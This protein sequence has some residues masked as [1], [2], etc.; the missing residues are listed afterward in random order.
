MT[1]KVFMSPQPDQVRLDTGIGQVVNQLMKHLPAFD[2]QLVSDAATADLVACHVMRGS[3]PRCDVLHS[4]GLYFADIPHEKY[5]PWHY[6]VNR[7][8][9]ASAREATLITVPAPWVANIFKRDM[10][11]SPVVIGHGV[12]ADDWQVRPSEGYALWNK[13]RRSDVCSPIPAY[14]LAQRGV[15]V[16]STFRP[17]D[18]SVLNNFVT[19]GILPWLEMKPEIERAECY[20]STTMETFGIGTLEALAAGVPVLG[21]DWGGTSDI[22]EHKV[23]GYLVK[24]GDYDGLKEGF[25]YIKSHRAAL[26]GAARL[27]STRFDWKKI[28]KQYADLYTHALEL[29]HAPRGVG[30]VVTCY[31]YAQYLKEAVESLIAQTRPIEQIVIVDDGSTDNSESVGRALSAEHPQQVQYIRQDNQG[32]AAARNHGI[33]LIHQPLV[34]CLDADDKLAPQY[35]AVTAAAMEANPALGIAYT[36]LTI[37]NDQGGSFSTQW[38]PDFDWEIQSKVSVPPSNCIPS[39]AMFRRAMWERAGGYIQFYAPGEDT[40]FWTRGLSVGF[41]AQKV[42]KEPMFLYRGHEG[43]A[44]RT[45]TY[46]AIDAWAPWMRDHAYPFASP[47]K[48]DLHIRSYAF[49]VV[50]VIIP[51]GPTH[52]Q[53]V[54]GALDSLLG[55]SFRDWEAI[56][57]NDAGETLPLTQYPFVTYRETSPGGHMGPGVARNMGLKLAKGSLVCFLDADDY[58]DPDF[59]LKTVKAY[60]ENGG[61]Y[62]YTDH[63]AVDTTGAHEG[64]ASEFNPMAW[65][66]KGIHGITVLMDTGLARSVQFNEVLEGWEDVDFF[67]RCAIMGIHGYHLRERLFYYRL[68]TGTRRAGAHAKKDQFLGW[69]RETYKDYLTGVKPMNSCCGGGGGAVLD[70]KRALGLSPLPPEQVAQNLSGDRVR[71]EWTRDNLAPIGITANG[72][73]YP[74]GQMP[75]AKYIDAFKQDVKE[76]E[77]K[78]FRVVNIPASA[79]GP[80]VEAVIESAPAAPV[81]MPTQTQ[82][83]AEVMEKRAAVLEKAKDDF[84]EPLPEGVKKVG[85][86]KRVTNKRKGN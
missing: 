25:E 83:A 30:V 39:A 60:T 5:D 49:P 26:S 79:Q 53:Y 76:L 72:R 64:A 8:I 33:E 14:E 42:A 66:D 81:T 61:R 10:R 3:L 85:E 67:M 69:L 15:R 43:S 54:R 82:T 23:T 29:R 48:R 68:Q 35:V 34:I 70:A 9:A 20:L 11:L 16:M 57:I 77:L 17:P 2:V 45:K 84:N 31:N 41:D 58:I 44:S 18:R 55:Q 22:V 6:R 13:N 73:V 80:T 36:G 28:I 71:M 63:Y 24:P 56:I 62:I 78:G 21:F 27:V 51:V 59:L 86:V 47:T 7:E 40:E 37:I 1:L 32:V 4:H 38:P 52:A 50:S 65:F 12:D 74:G 19:T 75:S 46:K